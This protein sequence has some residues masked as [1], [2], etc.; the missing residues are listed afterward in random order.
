MSP[1]EDVRRNIQRQVEYFDQNLNWESI[2]GEEGIEVF[3]HVHDLGL[4]SVLLLTH[5]LLLSSCI[6]FLT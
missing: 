1:F 3:I 2:D 4:S 5:S 6:F